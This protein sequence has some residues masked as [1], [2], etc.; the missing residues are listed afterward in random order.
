MN[1]IN[2]TL[3]IPLY[4]KSLVS[5]KGVILNDTT[6]ERIWNEQSIR[7]KG[8]SKSKWL[9]YFM[10][11]RAKVYDNWVLRKLRENPDVTV[12]HIGCGLDSRIERVNGYRYNWY[13][14]DM[15]D[16]IEVRKQFFVEKDGYKM[17]DGDAANPDFLGSVTGNS[18]VVILE[19]IS[20]YIAPK[21]LNGLF[22][23]L[24]ARFDDV[25]IL[26]DVYTPFGAKMT[27]AKNPINDVGV[28][29][30]YGVDNPEAPIADCDLKFEKEHSMTPQSLV[31][32]LQGVE[33][34][35]FRMMFAGGFAKKIYRM[36]EYVHFV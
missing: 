14:I 18:A 19:G 16:V 30:V 3:F 5:K 13:D 20:M 23:A 28:T 17:L 7:L 25:D 29:E 22:S 1:N 11:M 9:A 36:Y 8:K 15:P 31:E 2:K 26:M 10:A 4:G 32:E 24:Q 6:A 21:A 27:R 35:F 12:L 33:R 34:N